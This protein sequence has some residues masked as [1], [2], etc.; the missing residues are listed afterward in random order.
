[1]TLPH[2]LRDAAAL[3]ERREISPLE[4]TRACLDRIERENDAL[5]AFITVTAGPA[6]ADAARAEQDIAAHH[7]RGPLHGIPV[8]V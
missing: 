1:M 2:S 5:R 3:I 7:Y 6:L 4:L 8:W